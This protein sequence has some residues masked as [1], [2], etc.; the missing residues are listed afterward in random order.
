MPNLDATLHKAAINGQ[1]NDYYRSN[2]NG[3]NS[4]CAHWM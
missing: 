4:T 3:N 2:Y 1:E